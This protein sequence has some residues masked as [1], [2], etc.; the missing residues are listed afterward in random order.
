MRWIVLLLLVLLIM[1]PPAIHSYAYPNL[2]DDSAVHLAVMDV[3]ADYQLPETAYW[4][5]LIVGYPLVGIAE[6][7]GVSIDTAFLWWSYVMLALAVVVIFLVVGSLV[8]R[9]AGMIATVLVVFGTQG[10][11]YLFHY[12]QIFNIVNMLIVLPVAIWFLVK[13]LTGR[14]WWLVGAVGMTALF[15]VFHPTGGA[16]FLGD[17]GVPTPTGEGVE[18]MWQGGK[19]TT[20]AVNVPSSLLGVLGIVPIGLGVGAVVWSIRNRIQMRA[21]TKW[22][23]GAVAVVCLL[24]S[25]G[26]LCPNLSPDP[27]RHAMDLASWMA[28]GIATLT[29]VAL[30]E[31]WSSEHVTA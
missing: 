30:S 13:G 28:I 17:G 20:E 25:F 26:W 24:L 6:L 9:W 23:I 3:M 21:E 4:G 12:G 31:R 27:S 29:G 8:S 22:F 11:M 10:A 14:R 18:L 2:G 15:I 7:F 19:V 16:L 5:Q 1:L